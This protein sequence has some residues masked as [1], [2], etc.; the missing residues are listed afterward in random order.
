MNTFA[1]K[2][3]KQNMK[4]CNFPRTFCGQ[5][6]VWWCPCLVFTLFVFGENLN[7]VSDYMACIRGQG[8]AVYDD[9]DPAPENI[10]Y[11]VP[12]QVN[13]F[14]WKEEIMFCPS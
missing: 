4:W 12:Q 1:M 6:Q 7:P 9:N 11:Q 3:R 2:N 5:S 14:N 8:I 13:P 10:S